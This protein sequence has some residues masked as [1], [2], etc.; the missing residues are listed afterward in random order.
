MQINRHKRKSGNGR[1]SDRTRDSVPRRAPLLRALNPR[2]LL[3]KS[4]FI[5]IIIIITVTAETHGKA[6]VFLRQLM[7]RTTVLISRDEETRNAYRMLVKV[8]HLQRGED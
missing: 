2:A 6:T 1:W 3:A 5:I 7:S 4:K 8:G